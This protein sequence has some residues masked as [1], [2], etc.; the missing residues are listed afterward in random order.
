LL[1]SPDKIKGTPQIYTKNQKGKTKIKYSVNKSGKRAKTTAFPI[2]P[3]FEKAIPYA[4]IFLLLN[5]ILSYR[6]Y[7]RQRDLRKMS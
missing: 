1:S 5:N 7:C 3:K 4:Y 6:I 2:N